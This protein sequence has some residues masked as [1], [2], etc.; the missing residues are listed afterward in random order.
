MGVYKLSPE[1]LADRHLPARS[2]PDAPVP[3]H[4]AAIYLGLLQHPPGMRCRPILGDWPV[5]PANIGTRF[6]IWRE[7]QERVALANLIRTPIGMQGKSGRPHVLLDVIRDREVTGVRVAIMHV[8]SGIPRVVVQG[9]TRH[10]PVKV[11]IRVLQWIDKPGVLD[12]CPVNLSTGETQ[13]VDVPFSRYALVAV[14]LLYL[15]YRREGNVVAG[16]DGHQV[17]Y[18]TV[19]RILIRSVTGMVHCHVVAHQQ[20]CI[21]VTCHVDS[22]QPVIGP[23]VVVEQEGITQGSRHL[24]PDRMVQDIVL[25]GKED[26]VAHDVV[27]GPA[28][29]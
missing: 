25:T 12:K 13:K 29:T 7:L 15:P 3:G 19:I 5:G 23:H 4:N 26:A 1:S 28:H 24:D 14:Y 11:N 22:V 9:A 16:H 20:K 6:E 27:R 10:Q 21:A 2:A 17:A 8:C 18:D